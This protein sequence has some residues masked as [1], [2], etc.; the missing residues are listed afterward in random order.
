MAFEW[1]AV[2]DRMM[3]QVGRSPVQGL[4]SSVSAPGGLAPAGVA[5]C[6][7]ICAS[8]IV[9]AARNG[10]SNHYHHAG[11]FAHVVIAAAFSPAPGE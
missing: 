4:P 5:A 11:H 9:I 8:R 1:L 6:Q 3:Q 7:G 10:R 2:V